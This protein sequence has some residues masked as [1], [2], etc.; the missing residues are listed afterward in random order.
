MPNAK[1]QMLVWC[2]VNQ[3]QGVIV[4]TEREMVGYICH[5]T[6]GKLEGGI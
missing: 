6:N 3:V 2:S 1:C 4:S 5:E